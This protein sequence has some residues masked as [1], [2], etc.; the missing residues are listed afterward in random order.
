MFRTKTRSKKTETILD[1]Y[2]ASPPSAQNMLDVFRGEWSSRFPPPYE[3]LDAG[4]VPLF[5]DVRLQWM[6]QQ[7]GNIHGFR[8]L[9]LGPL[10]GGHSYMLDRAGAASVLAIEAN[11][12]AFLKCLIV[13]QILRMP[14]VE[15]KL[16]DFRPYLETADKHWDLCVGSGILYHMREPVSL[17]ERIAAHADRVYLWTHYFNE[18][19]NRSDPNLEWR[20]E[21]ER[22][23]TVG[24][25]VHRVYRYNY[26][27]LERK[28]FCGGSAKYSHWLTR[29]DILGALRHFGFRNFSIDDDRPYH[30][31]GPC[32]AVLATR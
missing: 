16:G 2:I 15:F 23:E 5:E 24:G 6:F 30:I 22:T 19:V 13:Q 21:K 4:Q 11:R 9:E 20:F 27:D 32:F 3:G 12:R 10:E 1:S 31:H 17:L 8:V 28:S 14:S 26:E 18:D 7:L 25:Y 29:D